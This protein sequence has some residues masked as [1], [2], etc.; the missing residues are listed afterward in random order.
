MWCKVL[1]IDMIKDKR[2]Q[3]RSKVN[4]NSD[5]Y[6][7]AFEAAIKFS[8]VVQNIKADFKKNKLIYS[9]ALP[10]LCY[11]IIFHYAPLYGAIIA[12]KEYTPG[13]GIWDSPWVGFRQFTAFFNSYYF[14]RVMKNT[15]LISVYELCFGF[16][17]PIIFALMLN[18]V[19]NKYFKGTVQTIVYL[20]HFISLV[21]VC[22]L[23]KAFTDSN[24][25][26][27]DIIVL[28]GGTESS[29]LL[30]PALFKP[31]YVLSGVWQEIGWGAIIYLAALSA[32]D[33]QLYEAA[34]LDGAGRFKQVVHVTIPGIAPT[35]VILL[36]MRMGRMLNVGFEKIIL[37]YNPAIYET[38]E[39]I[40]SYVYKVGLQQ[41]N[42]SF[43]TAVGLFNSVIN[44]ML[45]ILSNKIS[46]L[47][48]DVSLW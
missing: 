6:E 35:V 44:F 9:M 37:L 39:V 29:L 15:F 40:S 18:E 48:N 47:L 30:N 12:F 5:T 45:L 21:V 13:R 31:I 23:I 43:S 41:F 4:Q 11:Y 33:P 3:N 26:I 10:V 42:W 2:S 38:S 32:I 24:G 16:P 28:F 25:I 7:K 1:L 17:A 22:G 36:I 27:N 19:K 8:R 20:P 14:A 46:R 34:K